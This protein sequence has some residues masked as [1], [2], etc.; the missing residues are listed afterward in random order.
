[1]VVSSLGEIAATARRE[2]IEPPALVVVGE[3]VRL[4]EGLNWL[5]GA[6]TP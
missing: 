2:A 5:V 6:T 1:V 3:V 4:R